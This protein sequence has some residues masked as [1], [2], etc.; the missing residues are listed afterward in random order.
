MDVKEVTA[1]DSYQANS[2]PV[3]PEYQ[4]VVPIH[5]RNI[6]FELQVTS[7]QP[8][9]VSL[10]SMMWEGNYSPRFYKRT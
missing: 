6:N 2:E 5:Q 9:P 1:I 3:Q 10:V 4:F 7:N 8:Y